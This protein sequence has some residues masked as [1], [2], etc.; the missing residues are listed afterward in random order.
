MA[1]LRWLLVIVGL[2]IIVAVY[3][4]SRYRSHAR[5]EKEFSRKPP[6]G[7]PLAND[8]KAEAT[9]IPSLRVRFSPLKAEDQVLPKS[10]ASVTIS[11][12]A[13]D[14]QADMPPERFLDDASKAKPPKLVVLHVWA[15]DGQY[16]QGAQLTEAAESAN[17]KATDKNI[18]QYFHQNNETIPLFHVAN[19]T[20]PGT[21]EWDK[22]KQFKTQGLSLF[23]ELPVFC[24]AVE[25]FSLMHACAERLADLLDGEI[26]DKSYKPLAEQEIDEIRRVCSA[27]DDKS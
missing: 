9:D 11:G 22:M 3:I 19:K 12:R 1:E 14:F 18:F 21:F 27:M 16:W 10:P 2:A 5:N 6:N 24:S 17:L 20:Q 23:M 15:R 13:E 4:Y 25:A 7:D 8:K 26:L